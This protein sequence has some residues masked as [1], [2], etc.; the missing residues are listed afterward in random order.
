MQFSAAF[1]N[2]GR[3]P[4]NRGSSHWA[5]IASTLH[6][7]IGDD[8]CILGLC[9]VYDNNEVPEIVSALSDE[10]HRKFQPLFSP[11][12]PPGPRLGVLIDATLGRLRSVGDDRGFRHGNDWTHWLAGRV[13]FFRQGTSSISRLQLVIIVNHWDSMKRGMR[14]TM[15]NRE[16]LAWEV[17]NWM[18]G[19]DPDKPQVLLDADTKQ[20]VPVYRQPSLAMGDFNCEPGSPELRS[21]RKFTLQAM[22]NQPELWD[23]ILPESKKERDAHALLYDL[24]WRRL[25]Q[26]AVTAL[27]GTYAWGGFHSPAMI[28]RALVS[29]ELWNG[30]QMQVVLDN[31]GQAMRISPAIEGCS[32]HSAIAITVETK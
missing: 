3:R 2:C 29:R 20:P 32:D 23:S 19:K 8:L 10:I 31:H 12:K 26:S 14:D 7:V 18:C 4:G 22:R 15:A 13:E 28:D 6:Q 25:T 30:P 16:I 9:E 1:L 24:S 21:S 27:P 17:G 5:A 11:A